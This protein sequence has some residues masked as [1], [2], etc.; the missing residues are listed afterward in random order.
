MI[1]DR[2]VGGMVKE[3]FK[4]LLETMAADETL[5]NL[6]RTD[7]VNHNETTGF[8]AYAFSEELADGSYGDSYIT[9]RGSESDPSPEN[10][11]AM[12]VKSFMESI[13][14]G[15]TVNNLL[16]IDWIDN[17]LGYAIYDTSLQF[18]EVVDF[19][20]NNKGTNTYVTGHSK[21]GANALYACAYFDDVTGE[22]FD[23]HYTQ[24]SEFDY[25]KI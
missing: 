4:A 20:N 9:F 8:V 24:A 21:G 16:T 17:L 7:F 2:V 15:G 6:T 22:V 11:F 3:E 13:G 25:V 19:V 14:L 23:A 18:E 12:Y 1:G 5:A 10:G